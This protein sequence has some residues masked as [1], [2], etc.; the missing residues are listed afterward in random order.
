[1]GDFF[2]KL[3][4]MSFEE[5]I[6]PTIIKIAYIIMI[7]LSGLWALAMLLTMANL[8]GAGVVL[9]LLLAP[10]LFLLAV[11]FYRIALEA[12]LVLFS[13]AEATRKMA[14]AME[15]DAPPDPRE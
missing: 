14:S 7:A 15:Q 10:L 4:D 13:I 1:M 3:F 12:L 9:G 11:L 8:G 5:F 6:T 2:T